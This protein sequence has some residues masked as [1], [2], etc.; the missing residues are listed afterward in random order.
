MGGST[1][2]SL[3]TGRAALAVGLA[4]VADVLQLPLTLGLVASV[5]SGLG[6]AVMPLEA[7]DLAV[8]LTTAGLMIWLLGFHWALLPAFLLESVP[9][10]DV[11]P[12]WT[13]WVLYVVWRRRKAAPV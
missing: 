5:A 4:V 11:A 13:A 7:I 3:A 10:I 8:D 1:G 12:T 2:R 9:G 6:L